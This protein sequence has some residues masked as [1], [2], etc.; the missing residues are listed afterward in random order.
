MNKSV[1]I[2]LASIMTAM[3]LAVA[4]CGV[5]K[6]GDGS[7]E[8]VSTD[9]ETEAVNNED[10]PAAETEE[11]ESQDVNGQP[12]ESQEEQQDKEQEEANPE[13]PE[14]QQEE[15][16]QEE[17]EMDK[18]ATVLYQGHASMRITTYDGKVI[19]ID[20]FM[21]TGYDKAADLIL[22]TH[23]HY[24]HTA[25]DLIESKNDGCQTITWKEALKDGEHQSFDFGFVQVEAVEAGYNK[26]HNVNECVGYILTFENGVTLYVSGD[27]ST[28]QQMADL[29]ERQLDYA[30]FCCD[31]VYNMDINEASECAYLVNAKHN[32]PYHMIPANN[33]NGFDRDVAESFD[34]PGKIILAPGDELVL[35]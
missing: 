33:S 26:N 9:V 23:S 13:Q 4:G 17:E 28:T 19:Y 22:I 5:S 6:N 8:S 12:E 2:I 20:P 7:G 14:E 35:E 1:K 29:A 27:T 32:I 31:G 16:G 10:I 21:G 15:T 25:T 18:S 24:D 30:F 11:N 3:M 34:A